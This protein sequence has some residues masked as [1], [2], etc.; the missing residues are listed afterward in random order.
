M[1]RM[2]RGLVLAAVLFGACG[3][4]SDEHV[5]E[6]PIEGIP[7]AQQ[8]TIVRRTIA[9][10]WPLTVG[11]GTLG[12]RAGAVVFR[13]GGTTY[14]VNDAARA[15]GFASIDPIR[16]P[17]PSPPPS[18]PLK[19]R[20]QDERSQIFLELS[21]CSARTPQTAG[22]C[23]RALGARYRLTDWDLRQISTEGEERSWAPRQ[24]RPANL[25]PLVDRGLMFCKE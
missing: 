20:T 25:Q 21:K 11:K 10:D 4:S 1:G 13:A 8:E 3:P 7:L 5:V 12:C 9:K 24:R 18:N 6:D 22:D 23:T 17:E 15:Q 2:R 16:A 19:G 14:G